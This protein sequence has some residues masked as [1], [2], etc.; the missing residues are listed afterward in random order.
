[1]P[2]PTQRRGGDGNLPQ[3][4]V[5]RLHARISNHK[6][7]LEYS[8]K[9]RSSR[10]VWTVAGSGCL[11]RI[12]QCF[13]Y[14]V[15]ESKAQILQSLAALLENGESMK[16]NM[17]LIALAVLASPCLA[18]DVDYQRDLRPLFIEKCSACHGA[19]KQE[20][21]LRLD[22]G[23][24]IHQG[25]ENGAVIDVQAPG[26]S[27]LL[28]RVTTDDLDLRMPP[29]G[30]GE[31][32]RPDQ[33]Q[34]LRNWIAAG[35]KYPDDEA[36]PGGPES[37]WA[38]RIPIKVD[39][40]SVDNAQWRDNPIDAFIYAKLTQQGLKP[41]PLADRE[42]QLR[43]VYFDIV[44]LPPTPDQQQVFVANYSDDAWQSTVDELLASPAFGERWGRHWMDIWRYSDWDGYKQELRG[45]QRHIWRWRDWIIESLTGWWSRCWPATNSPRP[46]ERHFGPPATSPEVITRAIATFGSMRPSNT[47]PRRS[48]A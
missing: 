28:A 15:W 3:D 9:R 14:I 16:R 7:S 32:L 12:T 23:K 10:V 29:A 41:A 43:R 47:P 25:S 13:V 48:S 34:L 4:T 27:P 2:R 30:E 20:M 38:Y 5:R 46:I 31:P 37:H 17:G 44:G 8:R 6:C 33:V 24:L 39:V 26:Q 42:T 45:S 21:G 40:P 1:M 36:I 22:A 18:A 19:I 35:A 11:L